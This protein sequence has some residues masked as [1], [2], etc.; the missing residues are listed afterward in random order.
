MNDPLDLISNTAD[1]VSA[2]DAE[3]QIVFWNE[4]ATALFGYEAQEVLGRLCSEV[5]AGRD[6]A[7]RL[8]CNDRRGSLSVA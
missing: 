1:A 2:V 3:G 8:V 6:E 5:I 4:A 7:G